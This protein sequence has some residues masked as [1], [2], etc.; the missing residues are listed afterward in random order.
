LA[1][2][3][4]LLMFDEP[5]GALDR[6]LKETLIAELRRILH[7]TAVPAIYVTHDQEE[8]FGIADRILLLHEG[9]ILQDGKPAQVYAH[10]ASAWAAQFL[11]AGNVLPGVVHDGQAVTTFGIFKLTCSHEH[12]Q[13]EQIQLLVSSHHVQEDPNGELLGVVADVVFKQDEFKVILQN[14]LVFYLPRAPGIGKEIRLH[15]AP[16]SVQCLP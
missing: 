1:P 6:S 9:R 2:G 5:L 10:P 13:G 14:G 11:A 3:P 12:K 16:A 8:A 15:L 7:E 4:R